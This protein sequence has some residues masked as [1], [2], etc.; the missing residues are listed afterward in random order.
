MLKSLTDLE[1]VKSSSQPERLTD[2]LPVFP[3]HPVPDYY[4]MQLEKEKNRTSAAQVVTCDSQDQTVARCPDTRRDGDRYLHWD[5]RK[6][7]DKLSPDDRKL[8]SYGT[9]EDKK[10]LSL[11]MWS[12]TTLMSCFA[13][14]YNKF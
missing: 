6:P 11:E 12:C 5:Y 14:V 4:L 7:C 8:V 1:L 3:R 10:C 9:L 2:E 13:V